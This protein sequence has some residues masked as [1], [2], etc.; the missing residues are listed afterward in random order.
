MY[1][2]GIDC[3]I[4]ESQVIVL[5]LDSRRIIAEGSAAHSIVSNLADEVVEQHPSIWVRAIDQ[6]IQSCLSQ[7]ES[8]RSKIAGI[9]VTAF[10]NGVV[11]LDRDNHILR[12]AKIPGDLSTAKETQDLSRAFGGGPGFAEL[13]C[14]RPRPGDATAQMLWVKR[15]EAELF[16]KTHS[17]LMPHD[18]I[19][20]W[21][22]GIKCTDPGEASTTG[23]FDVINRCWQQEILDFIDPSLLH[24]L[25]SVSCVEEPHGTIRPELASQWN[26]SLG[27]TVSAGSGETMCRALGSGA[28]QPGITIVRLEDQI[29]VSALSEVPILDPLMEA[30]ARCDALNRWLTTLRITPGLSFLEQIGDHYEADLSELEELSSRAPVGAAG[31]HF[32]FKPFATDHP[33]FSATLHGLAAGNV[34]KENVCRAAMEAIVCRIAEG[35]HRLAELGIET[36]LIHV[37]GRGAESAL[38]RQMIADFCNVNVVPLSRRGSASLGAALQAAATFIFQRGERLKPEELAHYVLKPDTALMAKPD[39]DRHTLYVQQLSRQKDL[40]ELH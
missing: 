23:L 1:F 7:L 40:A 35:I 9:G 21:L 22:T 11:F 19:N 32:I 39:S 18:F 20:Y 31:M 38:L 6:A 10:S 13:G 2:L 12:P 14:N 33:D 24:R 8:K 17:V 27:T 15:Y 16:A 25:P 36:K 34:R 26:L 28:I 30:E 4:D 37:T 5:D 3:S 29:Q